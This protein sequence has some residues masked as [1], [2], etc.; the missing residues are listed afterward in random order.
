ML[1]GH[2]I[3]P[4]SPHAKRIKLNTQCVAVSPSDKSTQSAATCEAYMTRVGAR[5]YGS[6]L[7]DD[8][9]TVSRQPLHTQC[10]RIREGELCATDDKRGC[11]RDNNDESGKHA[12]LHV[13]VCWCQRVCACVDCF[14]V[15]TLLNRFTPPL[16][17]NA[18]RVRLTKCRRFNNVIHQRFESWRSS[19]VVV[20]SRMVT[21][22]TPWH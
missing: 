6:G 14:D 5:E 3:C 8:Y 17:P 15:V 19:C 1:L 21:S 11:V 13:C 10:A 9:L 2:L 4:Q 7:S 18:N 16:T 12:E 20:G 22:A